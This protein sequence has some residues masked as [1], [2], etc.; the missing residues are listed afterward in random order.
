MLQ[1]MIFYIV[2]GSIQRIIILDLH[3]YMSY[4]EAL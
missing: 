4:Q 3:E 1:I 2:T